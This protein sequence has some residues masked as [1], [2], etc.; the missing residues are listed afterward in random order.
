MKIAIGAD[1]AGFL[2]KEKIK[3]S[4]LQKGYNL[5][6]YG[7]DNVTACDYPDFALAVAQAV[8]QGEA[9]RGILVCGSGIGMAIAA[10]KVPH[11]RAGVGGDE[12]T[13]QLGRLHNNCNVLCLGART[14]PEE[15][16]EKLVNLWLET[17]FEGGR[18]QTRLDKI[19]GIEEKMPG[20]AK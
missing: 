4:L 5:K 11:I 15:L 12:Q 17:P 10:N 16:S 1:H 13:V 8:A 19:A 14:T 2:L 20:K 6:D 7:T 3:E 18:H 9:E